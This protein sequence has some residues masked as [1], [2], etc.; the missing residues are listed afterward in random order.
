MKI[1]LNQLTSAGSVS[2]ATS[3]DGSFHVLW[4]G[5]S[6]AIADSIVGA[7]GAACEGRW[8][9]DFADTEPA[10]FLVSTQPED[11][12]VCDQRT[13]VAPQGITPTG[14]QTSRRAR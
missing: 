3:P 12:F 13:V 11:W 9:K 7:L 14:V 10:A 2:I 4:Q 6:V 1:L 8:A 5:R